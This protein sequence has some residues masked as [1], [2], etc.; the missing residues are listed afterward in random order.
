MYAIYVYLLNGNDEVWKKN[1]QDSKESSMYEYY[2]GRLLMGS[3]ANIN[4][5]IDKFD[6]E[7]RKY[8]NIGIKDAYKMEKELYTAM[9]LKTITKNGKEGI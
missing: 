7:I 5:M 6:N 1:I 8:E 9:V 4:S 2:F 3:D